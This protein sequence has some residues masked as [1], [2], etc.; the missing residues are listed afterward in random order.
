MGRSYSLDMAKLYYTP[1]SDEVFTDMKSAA[2][3]I[4]N[5]YEDPYKSEKLDRIKDI[6]NVGDN[7]MYLFAMF[8]MNNQRKVVSSLS[9]KTRDELSARMIDGGNEVSFLA[10]LGLYPPKEEAPEGE[11]T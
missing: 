8:D 9:E 2:T 4:W 1:P 5:G 3:E 11:I 10:L 6:Q 7:F